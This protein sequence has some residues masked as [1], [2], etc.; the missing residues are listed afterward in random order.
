MLF[1][2]SSKPFFINVNKKYYLVNVITSRIF[3]YSRFYILSFSDWSVFYC[4]SPTK[5]L[6]VELSLQ[7]HSRFTALN[8]K[9]KQRMCLYDL[10]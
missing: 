5:H 4:S 2:I 9:I 3:E 8:P 10:L 6:R 7:Y 1:S